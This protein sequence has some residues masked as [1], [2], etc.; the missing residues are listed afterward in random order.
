MTVSCPK[1]VFPSKAAAKKQANSELYQLY[2]TTRPAGIKVHSATWKWD[3]PGSK[4]GR[5][6]F[7]VTY[8]D[9]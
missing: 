4:Y 5:F 2:G 7:R 9:R 3:R 6:E 8:L 1:G